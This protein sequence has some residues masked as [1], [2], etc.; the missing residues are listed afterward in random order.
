MNRPPEELGIG[1]SVFEPVPFDAAHEG[2]GGVVTEIHREND[3]VVAVTTVKIHHGRLHRCERLPVDALNWPDA[4][5]PAPGPIV[6]VVRLMAR[7]VG[8]TKGPRLSAHHRG[9][10]IDA[11]ALAVLL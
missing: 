6:P 9:L 1:W 8:S 11:G 7:D 5:R 3:E 2:R 4:C 10:L